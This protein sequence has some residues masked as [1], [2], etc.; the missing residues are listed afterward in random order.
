MIEIRQVAPSE[1][2]G[3]QAGD[4]PLILIDVREPHEFATGSLTDAINVP[5]N[6]LSPFLADRP[7][8]EL[9]VF[10]C[11]VGQR[12][13]QA[14]TFAAMVGYTNVASVTGGM[15]AAGNA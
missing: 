1:L 15:K 2:P 12:S 9:L 11:E 6:A 4:E 10:L 5:L 8:D 7:V 13:M 3:M 14:A